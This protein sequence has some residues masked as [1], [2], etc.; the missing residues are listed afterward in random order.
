MYRTNLV[1]VKF[2]LCILCF[3]LPTLLYRTGVCTVDMSSGYEPIRE[4]GS[5]DEIETVWTNER[6]KNWENRTEGRK[7][8][9][10]GSPAELLCN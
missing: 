7:E 1:C 5:C 3:I 9:Y 6:P 2:V 4:T 10:T 8:G